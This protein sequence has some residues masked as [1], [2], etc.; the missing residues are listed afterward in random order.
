MPTIIGLDLGRHS[1]RA[2]E[3]D[4]QK[5]RNVLIKN[6]T[7][8]NPRLNLESDTKEDVTGYSDSLKDFVRETGFKTSNAVVS[9]PEQQVY[10]R[11]IKIPE[12]NDKDLKDAIPFQAEQY[13]PLP[14]KEVSLSYQKIDNDII[15]KNKINVQLVAAKKVTL[16]KYVQILRGAGLVPVGIEPETLAIGRILGDS[17]DFPSASIIL[18]IGFYESLIIVTYRGFVRFTRSISVGGDILTR[19]ISQGLN[20]D[21]NQAEEYK[22]AYGLDQSQAEG[23]I[24]NILAPLFDNIVAEIKRSKIFFTTHNPNININRVILSGGTALMPGL[25]LYMAN[26]LDLEVELANP[27][28]NIQFSDKLSHKQDELLQEGPVYAP[29]VGLALKEL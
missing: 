25:F 11:I 27:W 1:F 24:Y 10:M 8:E 9:L 7:Y 29:S 16:E 26:N 4:R 2:V 22:K 28:K 23:K 17:P 20:F 12:V 6:A 21:Y 14:L 18:N 19:A 3:I 13:I 5:D 15:E